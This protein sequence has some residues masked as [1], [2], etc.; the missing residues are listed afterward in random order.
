MT[1]EQAPEE[2]GPIITMCFTD[3]TEESVSQGDSAEGGH[4]LGKLT[5]TANAYV[6]RVEV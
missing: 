2:Q 5:L 6:K 4:V 1:T 3:Y